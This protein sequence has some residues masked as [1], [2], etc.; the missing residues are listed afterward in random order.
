MNSH[1]VQHDYLP[2]FLEIK[3]LPLLLAQYH[4]ISND[5]L[6]YTLY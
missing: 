5:T 1:K 2:K 6:G 4:S 3:S